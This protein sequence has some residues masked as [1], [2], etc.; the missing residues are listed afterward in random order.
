MSKLLLLN[1]SGESWC[2]KK[3]SL[4]DCVFGTSLGFL[5]YTQRYCDPSPHEIVAEGLMFWGT[6][7]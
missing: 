5:V 6:R 2:K 4:R 7:F 1:R 3:K